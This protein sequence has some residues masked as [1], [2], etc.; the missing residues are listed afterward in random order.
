MLWPTQTASA[1][2]LQTTPRKGRR[3]AR[4]RGGATRA[5]LWFQFRSRI[6]NL[7]RILTP[8]TIAYR[9]RIR[10]MRHYLWRAIKVPLEADRARSTAQR[11][12]AVCPCSWH[13]TEGSHASRGRRRRRRCRRVFVRGSFSPGSVPNSVSMCAQAARAVPL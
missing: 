13:R 1:A 7:R 10:A 9:S 11:L 5:P 4:K 2:C 6:W 8:W 12:H 3:R